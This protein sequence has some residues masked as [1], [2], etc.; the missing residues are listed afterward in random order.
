MTELVAAALRTKQV[1]IENKYS[2][3]INIPLSNGT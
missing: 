1:A 2:D 3:G